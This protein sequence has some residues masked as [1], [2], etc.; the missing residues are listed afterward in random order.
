MA[1][2]P[3]CLRAVF[4]SCHTH[5]AKHCL[6]GL[7][8]SFAL[9]PLQLYDYFPM[10]SGNVCLY[11]LEQGGKCWKEGRGRGGFERRSF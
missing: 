4:S 2:N 8:Y 1:G 10:S 11:S 5:E 7:R 6:L 3:G 9:P